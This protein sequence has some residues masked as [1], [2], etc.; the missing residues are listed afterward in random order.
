MIGPEGDS[1]GG[2]LRPASDYGSPPI[3]LEVQETDWAYAATNP[4]GNMI[5]KK[6]RI[7]YKG[8]VN[9]PHSATIDSMFILQWAD[10]DNG[11]YSDDF[12]G[13]DTN[14]SLGY[15]YNSTTF[16]AIYFNQF[17]LPP[18]AGGFDFLQGPI[19]P[20]S[21]GDSAIFDLKVRY[22]YK[23]LP[24][25]TFTYFAAGSSRNDPD[26]GGAYSGTLQWYNLMRGAEARPQYPALQPLYDQFGNVTHFELSGDPVTGTGDLDGKPT[27]ANTNR[28]PPGDRRI[29]L[30]SGPFTM[31]RGDTQEIVTALVG[32]LGKNYLSSVSVLKF[33]TGFARFAYNNFFDLPSPPAQPKITVANLDR[34]L[35]L[36]WGT[37]ETSVDKTENTPQKGFVFEGYNIYQLPS[38]NSQLSD[39]IRLAT[40][41]LKN[42][43][44]IIFDNVF[45]E[46]SGF[47]ITKPVQFGSNSGIQ[48]FFKITKDASRGNAPLVD[49]QTY[50]FAVTAYSYNGNLPPTAPFHVLESSPVVIITSPHSTNPGVRYHAAAGDTLH[51]VHASGTSDGA[52]V[53]VV[54]DTTKL[55]GDLYKVTFSTD[56]TTG[57]VVWALTDSTKDSVVLSNQTNQSGDENYISV[58]GVEVKVQG[59]PPGM[60]DYDIPSGE[61][62]WTPNNANFGLEGFSGAMGMAYINWFSSSSTTPDKL[63]NV[64]IKLAATDVNG[65]LLNPSDTTASFAYRYLRHASFPAAEPSFAPYIV[66]PGAGYA[67]QD[68]TRHL[69]F[70]AYDEET[71]HRLMVGFLENN[72]TGGLVDGKYWPPDYSAAGADNVG[73]QREWFFIFDETYSET[74]DVALEAD[75]LD[76]VLP[77]MWMGTPCRR[78][79]VAFSAGDEFEILANHINGPLDVFTYMSVAPT[80]STAVAKTDVEQINVFPN[81]YYGF[82]AR[83]LTRLGKYVTFNHLPS[84]AV[85]RIFNLAGVLVK[86]IQHTNGTQFDTW[87]LRNESQLPVASGIYIVYIDMPGLQTTKV[88][89]LA[90]IQEE[91]I[92][93][94]Y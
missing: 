81:P 9:T 79:D 73:T 84:A 32:G 24:M 77:I 63:H 51:T 25:T 62:R 30:S 34:E 52:V 80:S 70:A 33:N 21:P 83:E 26:R 55:T 3:G 17:G 6:S 60:K 47:V 74:P 39:G 16:D 5:F 2:P 82:N 88:L 1:R 48:R 13:C 92:L 37:D 29:V 36:N 28:L 41:D 66:N 23:N 68:Y 71:G 64:L 19:I 7:I 94:V 18:P 57:G 53:P 69:P 11:Q 91:Q 67:Y 22:G 46:A 72:A 61:R 56:T 38:A 14:L 40:F 78:G 75:I 86:T 35:M 15:V 42:L 45:D 54:L 89:K 4:L 43:V 87:N 59:P 90:L 49:G 85:I 93:R 44:S 58:G 27:D 50:Y 10:P 31:T 8:T 12:A 76:D 65:N 20:G